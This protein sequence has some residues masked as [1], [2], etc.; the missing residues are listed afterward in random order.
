MEKKSK[1]YI[2]GHKGLV[3]SA[4]ERVLKKEGYENIL[5]KT[6][7]E[8]DLTEQSRVNEFFETNRPEYVFLAAAK[9]GGIH[10]NNTYPAEFIFSNLQIQNNIID[11]CYRFKTKKLLFLGSSCIYPKFARQPMDEGQLL[12]GKLEPTNEPYAVAKI[13]GIVMCQSY[14]RQYGTNFISVM[15]TNLYG[16]GDNYHPENS[17]VLPAL[18]RR[19]YEAKIKNL[20]EVIIW[21]TG[22][23]LREFLYSDDMASACVFLMKNYD[24]TGD[25]KGG[26]HVNVGSGIEVS[27][28]ELAEVVKEVVE[29]QGLLTFDLTKPDGTPRK[30]LDVSKL[31]K[32]GWRHRVEL[33]E[34]IRLAFE[35]YKMVI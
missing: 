14:N 22:K 18:I 23:P 21:G 15:P 4:I 25:P 12:D 24:V 33:R 32:M 19:F 9:V 11:A 17:H 2:A 31:H 27:I 16:P 30:L 29:Y 13:A 8:L 20:P 1:I 35:D 34:G 7:A 10:A 28:R 26:E 5:G 6:H 3:G